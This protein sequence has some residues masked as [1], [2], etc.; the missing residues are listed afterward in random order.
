MYSGLDLT[1]IQ[2]MTAPLGV[3]AP[4]GFIIL[5]IIATIFFFPGTPITVTGGILF[6]KY[7]GA[8][9]SL[10][11]ATIG[12]SWAFLIARYLGREFI[13]DLLQGKLKKLRYYDRKLADHGIKFTIFLRLVPLFP[14]NGLN[15]ALGLTKIKFKDFVI[16]T[17]IGMIP[18]T[19]IY[20][21]FGESLAKMSLV[22]IIISAS[23]VILFILGF[24][25]YEK[26]KK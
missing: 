7:L 6:G 19:F 9:Y 13:E 1:K 26:F 12:A 11:G 3:F 22:N 25:L 20:A 4:L 23:L 14:F 15:F 5:Y 24:Y 10:I 17:L 2:E 8:F 18:L 21:Y 16:G